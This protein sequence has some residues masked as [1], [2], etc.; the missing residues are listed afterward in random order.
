M[1]GRDLIQDKGEEDGGWGAKGSGG[2]SVVGGGWSSSTRPS[3]NQGLSASLPGP[4]GVR[5]NPTA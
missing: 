1:R 3:T 5:P 2:G 4:D